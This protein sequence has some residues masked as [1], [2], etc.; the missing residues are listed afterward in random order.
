MGSRLATLLTLLGLGVALLF[1]WIADDFYHEDDI[2]H[3]LLVHDG[4]QD[5]D[6]AL[7]YW[8]RPGFTL[9]MMVA[10][11]VGGLRGCRVLS[12]LLTGLTAWLAWGIARRAWAAGA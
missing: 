2:C 5:A 12:A 1:A 9:P 8:A 11:R 10:D 4:W 6:A 7:H 3:Y